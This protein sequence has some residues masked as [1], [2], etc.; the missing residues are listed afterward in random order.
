M[1][2]ASVDKLKY[3]LWIGI[4]ETAWKVGLKV[5]WFWR[6]SLRC[7]IY[8][9]Q[10]FSL[11]IFSWLLSPWITQK[12]RPW[13][14][15]KWQGISLSTF[16]FIQNRAEFYFQE[17]VISSTRIILNFSLPYLFCGQRLFNTYKLNS[18]HLKC[19]PEKLCLKWI[20]GNKIGF[21]NH[22]GNLLFKG[23]LRLN[24][25]REKYLSAKWV[26]TL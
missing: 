1:H 9:I 22:K 24:I 23:S 2:L 16:I 18:F 14:F 5:P 10:S 13:N 6:N 3:M 26:I 8:H 19:T 21:L 25:C 11:F 20:F 7:T 12:L 4:K 15:L 17:F